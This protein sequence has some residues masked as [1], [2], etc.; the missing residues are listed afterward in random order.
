[1]L[2]NLITIMPILKICK[3]TNILKL[4]A[5]T[6]CFRELIQVTWFDWAQVKRKN[7]SMKSRNESS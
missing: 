7:R 3:L 1:M 2:I 5:K 4:C 6:I